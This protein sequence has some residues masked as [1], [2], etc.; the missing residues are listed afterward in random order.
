M[1]DQA[2]EGLLSP[3]L[4]RRRIR[5]AIPHVRGRVLDHGC[6]NGALASYVPPGE[7]LGVDRDERSLAL[8]RAR[9]PRHRFETELPPGLQFDTVVSLAVIEHVPD[10]TS[11]LRSLGAALRPGGRIVL[12]TPHPRAEWLHDLGARFRL[13]SAHARDEHE[14]L[15]DRERIDVVARGAGLTVE[16]FHRFLGGV[17]QLAVLV[18]AAGDP[19]RAP[20]Q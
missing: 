6:G 7:Y 2:G 3:F 10:P 5:A 11:L 4:Q 15:L 20:N 16:S 1:A 19:K 17:N 18:C 13:F 8:A 12:S 14:Q 9:Y